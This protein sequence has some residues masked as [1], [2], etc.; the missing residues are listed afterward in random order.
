MKKYCPGCSVNKPMDEF[1][2]NSSRYDGK[3]A[4]CIECVKAAQKEYQKEYYKREQSK[5]LAKKRKKKWREKNRHLFNSQDKYNKKLVH[6]MDDQYIIR[7]IKGGKKSILTC[8]QI[9]SHPQLI[10]AT[11]ARLKIKRLIN[12]NK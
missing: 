1:Y 6:D 12:Q 7:I 4:H 2:N 3:Q 10:E 8:D 9:R 11:R 5:K